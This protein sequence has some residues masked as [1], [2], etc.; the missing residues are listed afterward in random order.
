MTSP[1][2][3]LPGWATR[4]LDRGLPGGVRGAS[5]QGDLAEEY[6]MRPAGVVREAW[7]AAAVARLLYH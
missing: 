7:L 1:T 2:H 6:S 4:A 5:I 3:R